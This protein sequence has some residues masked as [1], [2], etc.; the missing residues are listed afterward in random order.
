MPQPAYPD[1]LYLAENGFWVPKEA[2]WAHLQANAKQPTIGKVLDDAMLAVERE[3]KTL[4]HVLPK[5]FARLTLDS[6]RLGELIDLIGTI[7]LRDTENRSKDILGR[8]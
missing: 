7:R 5:E 8:G 6:Q 4:K 2:R 1:E 3:N